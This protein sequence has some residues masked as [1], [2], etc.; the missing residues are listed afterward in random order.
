MDHFYA[1]VSQGKIMRFKYEDILF[2]QANVDYS[3]IQLLDKK[4]T[5]HVT[6]KKFTELLDP[7]VFLQVHRS[8]ICN[9]NNIEKIEKVSTRGYDIYIGNHI[10]P[11]SENLSKNLLDKLIII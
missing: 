2:I 8:Y 3:N 9:L 6:M 10:I 11:V 1:K 7:K 4:E 5:V